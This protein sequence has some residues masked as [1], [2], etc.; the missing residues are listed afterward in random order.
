MFVIVNRKRIP[1]N[2]LEGSTLA[3]EKAAFAKKKAARAAEISAGG[4]SMV[5]GTQYLRGDPRAARKK[6]KG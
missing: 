5:F 1:V 2:Q 6:F 4:G 3:E